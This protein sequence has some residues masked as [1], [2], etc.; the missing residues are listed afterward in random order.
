[1]ANRSYLYSMNKSWVKKSDLSE[2]NQE[3]PLFYKI[4]LGVE[5]EITKS[6]IF[7]DYEYPIAFIGNFRKG[8]K[9]YLNLLEYLQIVSDE[10]K[11]TFESYSTLTQEFFEHNPGKK[12]VL[13]LLEPG[14]IF[15]LI[16]DMESPKDQAENLLSEIET[17]SKEIEA[18]LGIKKRSL[19]KEPLNQVLI[20]EWLNNPLLLQP[21]WQ[22]E[23]YYSFNHSRADSYKNKNNDHL[24][25]R[26]K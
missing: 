1:M 3:I 6:W 10:H 24:N 26:T 21:Y 23:C 12:S 17:I 5:T 19:R 22:A 16:A 14:E 2:F 18:F 8:L 25:A 9:R 15:E 20:N 11:D 13:F 4:L 7:K